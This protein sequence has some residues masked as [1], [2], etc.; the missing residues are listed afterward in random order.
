ML[1]KE[2]TKCKKVLT[3]NIQEIQDTIKR[4]RLRI[5]EIEEGE[6]SQ[7]KGPENISKKS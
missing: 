3:Q 1:F 7:L 2:S 4:P 5:I 6:E